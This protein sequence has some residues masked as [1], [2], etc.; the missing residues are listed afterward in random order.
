[1][2]NI[3]DDIKGILAIYKDAAIEAARSLVRSWLILP[4]SLFAYTAFA[5]L[6]SLVG[7]LGM[8]GGFIAGLGYIALLS[9]FYNWI[10]AAIRKEKIT[11]RSLGEFDWSLFSSLI[12]VGFVLWI[13]HMLTDPLSMTPETHWLFACIELG[14]FILLNA[15][16]EIVY[17]RRYESI[18]AIKYSFS[19]IKENWIEWF[20]PLIALL[21]PILLARP[22]S[23][24]TSLA[25]VNPFAAGGDPL[26]PARFIFS[27]TSSFLAASIGSLGI[28]FA[29]VVTVWFML[30]RGFLFQKLDGTSRRQRTYKSKYA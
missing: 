12:S 19:F 26:F 27:Q 3:K 16:P 13:A 20:A 29:I 7:G 15:I 1:M 2:T 6:L 4:A 23:V 21:L 28:L 30:F 5:F 9:F 11:F 14:I 10:A 8:A 25:G 18:A 24:L 22:I 17:I